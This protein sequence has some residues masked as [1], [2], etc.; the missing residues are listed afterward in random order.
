MLNATYVSQT[1]LLPSIE[2]R[3]MNGTPDQVI[4]DRVVKGDV[5]AFSELVEKYQDRIYS[6]VMNYVFNAEDAVDVVQ[7]TFLKAY[8]KLRTFNSSSAFYTWIY[9]IAINTAIDHIR[10]RKTRMADSLDDEKY[11]QVGFEPTSHDASVD[12]EKVAVQSE[13]RRALTKAISELSDKLRA[14]TVLHD[15]EGLSQE[16]VAEVL[17][18]PVGT[19]KS[20]VSRAR[21][22]LRYILREQMGE[23]V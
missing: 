12:P 5:D 18:V 21:A 1:A 22:E 13:S 9:R 8:S 17:G 6:V 15:V 3:R 19:V 16:E 23:V 20:R 4:V 7:D 14:V 11:T 2:R 10:K